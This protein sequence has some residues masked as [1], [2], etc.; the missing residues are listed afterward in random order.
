MKVPTSQKRQP[1]LA[2]RNT[3]R[4][5]TNHTSRAPNRKKRARASAL[6]PALRE[7]RL[8]KPGLAFIRPR[9]SGSTRLSRK[10]RVR[11]AAMAPT[12]PLKPNTA[13]STPPRK[14]PTPLRAFFEPVRIAT[15][16]NRRSSSP[17]SA[18]VSP[19]SAEA[20]LPASTALIA[21]LALILLR[22]L[23]MPLKA[24]AAI[25]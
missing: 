14:K 5:T 25:T 23:A 10:A 3:G 6:M 7:N 22:S 19:R 11:P 24:W 4:A 15:Q 2:S 9:S 20:L 13:S 8:L 1:R 12:A 17:R 18:E 16:R 21:P